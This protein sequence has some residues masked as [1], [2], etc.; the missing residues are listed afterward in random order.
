MRFTSLRGLELLENSKKMQ[1]LAIVV[2]SESVI[3][4]LLRSRLES[5]SE[6]R[7]DYWRYRTSAWSGLA[8]R[9]SIRTRLGEPLKR[10]VSAQPLQP[11]VCFHEQESGWH[12]A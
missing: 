12:D 7:N 2:L 3:V 5:F 11:G 4:L 6:R 8:M 1:L 10:S 9:G